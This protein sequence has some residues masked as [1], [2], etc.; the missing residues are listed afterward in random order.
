MPSRPVP[1]LAAVALLA[2]VYFAAAKFG[3]ALAFGPASQVT[4]VWPPTGIALAA[5][6]LF[7]YRMWPGI[8][9]GALLANATHREPLEVAYGIATGNTLEAV[10]GAFLLERWVGFRPSLERV[11][12]IV[13]LATLAAILSTM[14]SATVG[15]TSLCL[16]GLQPWSNFETLWRTWWLGDA[17]GDLVFAP[18]LLSWARWSRL[19][20]RGRWLEVGAL[21]AGLV[22]VSVA[23]FRSGGGLRYEADYSLEYTIFPFAIWAALRFGQPGS[24]VVILT[25]MGIAIWGTID[26]LGPFAARDIQNSLMLLHFYMAVVAVTTFMLGAVVTERAMAERRRA[27]G[28]AVTEVL[29]DSTSLAHAAPRLLSV[30]CESLGY[31]VGGVWAVDR[32]ARVL[33]CV[34]LW[35]RPGVLVDEFDSMTRRLTFAPGI[36][37]PGRIW[38]GGRPVWIADVTQDANFPRAAVAAHEG[39]HGAFGFPVVLGADILGVLEFF[40]RRIQAPDRDLLETL[41]AIGSQI[42]QF[43]ER[44]RAEE[45]VRFQAHML[46]SIGQATIATR[47]DG[48]IFYW[49]RFAETLYNWSAAEVVGKNVIDIVVPPAGRAAAQAI[50]DKLRAGKSWSGELTVQRKDGAGFPVLVTDTPVFDKLGKPAGVIGTYVDI[51]ERKRADRRKDEFLAMLAHELRNPL[52]PIRNAVQ[53]LK[54]PGVEASTLKSTRDIM[55]RQVEHLV[56]LVDDLLDVSRIMRGKIELRKERIALAG[57]VAR[58]VETADP[59]IQERGHELTVAI[60]PEAIFL[61]ADPVRMAQVIANLLNNAAKYTEPGGRITLSAALEGREAVV[62]VRDTGIGIASE[63]LPHI[64]DLF[65]QA[66]QSLDRSQGGMGIGLTLVRTLVEM[67]GGRV[68]VDSAGLGRGSEFFIRLPAVQRALPRA[69]APE[70]VREP[71]DGAAAAPLPRRRVLVV[72]D[73]VDAAESLAMLLRLEGQE[74]LVAHDGP[75]AL[76]AAGAVPPDL[77]FLDIGMP[78]M[79]GYEV[80]RRL[81]RRPG[82]RKITLVALTGWGQEEDRL[83]SLEAGFDNHFVKPVEPGLL[84]ELLAR[85]LKPV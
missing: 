65:V 42:G 6:L 50:M 19:A 62:R 70:K 5:L 8:A 39:L 71:A 81:R 52:A 59:A 80:A 75:A 51:S 72:D 36:G 41:S 56:R 77:V 32:E 61:N 54:M 21:L 69:Q 23:V 64:F 34:D 48:T 66:D 35:R 3:L 26:G 14:I 33:R 73:N 46:D 28:Y 27:V 78:G 40:H 20:W 45:Q 16:G 1:Y 49:N 29:A 60:P 82:M 15:V 2:A 83:R 18:I 47:S 57:A 17:M 74:V 13:S 85:E 68:G 31:D 44:S 30:I 76:E 10:A 55:E 4:V 67:H 84:Q 24:A 79:D 11:R 12:D 22:V 58:A 63:M 7:G 25:A 9:L 53:I 38:L 37:L 43:I